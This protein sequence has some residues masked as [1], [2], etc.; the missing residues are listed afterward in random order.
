MKN[1][2]KLKPKKKNQ[3]LIFVQ[4]ASLYIMEQIKIFYMKLV[5]A[6]I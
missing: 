1:K 3:I 4:N 6:Q 5:I 2:T